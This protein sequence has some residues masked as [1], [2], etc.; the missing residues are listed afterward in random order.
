MK[1]PKMLVRTLEA[2][3]ATLVGSGRVPPRS[4][5]ILAKMGTIKMSMKEAASTAST[6]TTIG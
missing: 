4:P 5:N 1:T 2:P 3:I 6:S